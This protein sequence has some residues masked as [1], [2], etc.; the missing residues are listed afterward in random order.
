MSPDLY[1]YCLFVPCVDCLRP[2]LTLL[3]LP[4]SFSSVPFQFP[5]F[6]QIQLSNFDIAS[7]L[8]SGIS[9]V[10]KGLTS[11]SVSRESRFGT[12]QIFE[13]SK[14]RRLLL[15]NNQASQELI[16]RQN[17]PRRAMDCG[18]RSQDCVILE[19]L[20]DERVKIFLFLLKLRALVRFPHGGTYG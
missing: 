6:N 8:P 17:R 14:F 2:V 11:I 1:P 7:F 13:D 10:T 3:S 4:R 20:T 15:L 9:T 16:V 18:L 12:Y 19:K 5:T